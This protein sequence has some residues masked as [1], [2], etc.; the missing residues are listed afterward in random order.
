MSTWRIFVLLCVWREATAGGTVGSRAVRR[1]NYE[2]W[3]VL[4]KKVIKQGQMKI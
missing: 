1:K 3:G 2:K 4:K